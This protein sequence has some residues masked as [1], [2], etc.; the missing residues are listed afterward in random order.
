[1]RR[2]N[3][4]KLNFKDVGGNKRMIEL[5]INE[6][7]RNYFRGNKDGGIVIILNASDKMRMGE[8]II[9]D[10]KITFWEYQY[11]RNDTNL[12]WEVKKI[13]SENQRFKRQCELAYKIEVEQL[14]KNIAQDKV[15]KA[16]RKDKKLQELV[17][18]TE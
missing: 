6:I 13:K 17:K 8:A 9:T 10:S 16:R 2:K 14:K 5:Y 7:I 1:M 4:I 3:L 15:T 18:A 12:P 11:S